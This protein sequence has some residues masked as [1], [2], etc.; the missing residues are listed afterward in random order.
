MSIVVSGNVVS[1]NI[2]TCVDDFRDLNVAFT[3]NLVRGD[4]NII[5]SE[6]INNVSV[7]GCSIECDLEHMSPEIWF[8]YHNIY[9]DK[10][11]IGEILEL[12]KDGK[13]SDL[14][15]KMEYKPD[16]LIGKQTIGVVVRCLEFLK[17]HAIRRCQMN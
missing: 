14:R 5:S 3:N 13:V 8:M 1:G 11:D 17:E 2:S 6:A 10:K 16:T 15:F 7:N 9:I 12:Y 4:A